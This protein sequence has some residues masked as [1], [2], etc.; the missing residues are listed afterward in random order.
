VPEVA[1]VL[2]DMGNP[3]DHLAALSRELGIPMITGLGTATTALH[4][5]DWVLADADRGLVLAADPRLWRDISRPAPRAR[6]R[7]DD[8]AANLRR[9]ILP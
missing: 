7:P 3:L 1:A 9:M 5:G 2:V 6:S 4:H 8:A